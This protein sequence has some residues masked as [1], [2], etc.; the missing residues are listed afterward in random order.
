MY[1]DFF[2]FKY[3]MAYASTLLSKFL[4]DE[5]INLSQTYKKVDPVPV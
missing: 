4:K 3:Y 2:L 1:A 5:R